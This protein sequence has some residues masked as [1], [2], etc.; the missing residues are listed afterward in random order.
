MDAT[1]SRAP[2]DPQAGLT[3]VEIMVSLLLVSVAAAFV[4]SIQMR[5]STALRDQQAIA[6]MQQTLR[7][8]SDQLVRDLRGAGY[9][10]RKVLMAR[11]SGS[12]T[13]CT[14]DGSNMFE[15]DSVDVENSSSGP[16][17]LRTVTADTTSS[18]AVLSLDLAGGSAEVDR[19]DGFADE[20]IIMLV[21]KA[22]PIAPPNTFGLG[23]V[24][25][26]TGIEVGPPA[27]LR[28]AP[29]G[30]GYNVAG[31]CHCSAIAAVGVGDL[32]IAKPI[33]HAYRI[34]ANDARGVLQMSP[35]GGV[36]LNDWLDMA[37]GIVDLQVALRVVVPGDVT[38]EDGDGDAVRDWVSGDNMEN[39]LDPIANDLA[40]TSVTLVAKTSKEVNGVVLIKTPDLFAADA[41]PSNNRIG[42]RPGTPLPDSDNTSMYYGEFVYRSYTS[43]VNMRN[44]RMTP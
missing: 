42:D 27:V 41:G 44:R 15:I 34:S 38:D 32:L 2:R 4:F 39:A 6:E 5:T 40:A 20:E 14:H 17:L 11:P 30:N 10:A 25:Q 43:T 29:G 19:V 21:S 26:L 3:M 1:G 18:A 24:L 35:T 8:A 33:V 9:L 23:C 12:G 16:D 31:N 13:V 37:V 22:V 28:F 36:A 7:S